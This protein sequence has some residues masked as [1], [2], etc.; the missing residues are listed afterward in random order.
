MFEDELSEQGLKE[1][2]DTKMV[3]KLYRQ[4]LQA[5]RN[6]EFTKFFEVIRHGDEVHQAW[7][8]GAIEGFFKVRITD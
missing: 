6:E 8:K 2:V 3:E 1:A 4:K 5:Q 7:L